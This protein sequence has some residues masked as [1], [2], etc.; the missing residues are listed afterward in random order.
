MS[1]ES[2]GNAGRKPPEPSPNHDD[3]DHWFRSQMPDL[4]NVVRR[5]DKAIRATLPGLYY[6]VK[7]KRAY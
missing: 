6:A 3:I 4:Q 2:K 7:R 5:L 1:K